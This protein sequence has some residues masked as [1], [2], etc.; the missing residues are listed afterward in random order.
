MW[1]ADIEE[2]IA[3]VIGIVFVVE[4]DEMDE[5]V[6]LMAVATVAVAVVELAA[7]AVAVELD[8]NRYL[9]IQM[10]RGVAASTA[11]PR[12]NLSSHCLNHQLA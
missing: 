1:V 11:G 4:V 6:G 5:V 8:R 7:V 2:A 3:T 10:A 9:Q 12:R